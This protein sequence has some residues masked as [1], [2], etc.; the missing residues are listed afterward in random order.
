[1]CGIGRTTTRAHLVPT[2]PPGW[3][4]CLETLPPWYH[5]YYGPIVTNIKH[6]DL[7]P[8]WVDRRSPVFQEI[9]T[10][11]EPFCDLSPSGICHPGRIPRELRKLCIVSRTYD[12]VEQRYNPCSNWC[13]NAGCIACLTIVPAG[14]CVISS[15]PIVGQS[16]IG[17]G[18]SWCLAGSCATAV[19]CCLAKINY[20]PPPRGFLGYLRSTPPE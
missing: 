16:L 8:Y 10:E 12:G 5:P 1:M 4:R 13:D 15:N 17:I 7:D 14:A 19:K 9:Y 20:G 11:L 2:P 18:G 3:E 6:F